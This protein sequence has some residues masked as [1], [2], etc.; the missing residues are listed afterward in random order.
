MYIS[1]Y[2]WYTSNI[3]IHISNM[4]VVFFTKTTLKYSNVFFILKKITCI[5]IMTNVFALFYNVKVSYLFLN[6]FIMRYL[7][8]RII[9]Q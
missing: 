7:R 9:L 6:L 1:S 2:K 8:F 5:I 3:K 4:N